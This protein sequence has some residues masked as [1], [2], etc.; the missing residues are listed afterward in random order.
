M[1]TTIDAPP[2]QPSATRPRR[3]WLKPTILGGGLL[4]LGIIIGSSGSGGT[5]TA[6]PA[7]TV[8]VAAAPSA[9]A[10]AKLDAQAAALDTR[11]KALDAREAAVKGAEVQKAANT[12]TDGTWTV[13]V[14]VAAGAYRT[15][16]PVSGSC[17]W[18]ITKSGSNGGDIINNDIVQGGV[19]SVNLAA[20]QDFKSQ[21]CGDWAKQ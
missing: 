9:D 8:T 6:T 11:G 4:V 5:T 20:G 14:N 15:T 1:S 2:A 7:P 16:A 3:R 19:P 13:G 12:I 17:Y 10:Q 21:G 18:S